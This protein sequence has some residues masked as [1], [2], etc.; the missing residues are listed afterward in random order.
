MTS[1]V[2]VSLSDMRSSFQ[3]THTNIINSCSFTQPNVGLGIICMST[4]SVN[5]IARG[6]ESVNPDE[7][8]DGDHCFHRLM[9]LHNCLYFC[10]PM[11]HTTNQCL[12]VSR[13]KVRDWNYTLAKREYIV[14]TRLYRKLTVEA[15]NRVIIISLRNIVHNFSEKYCDSETMLQNYLARRMKKNQEIECLW[16]CGINAPPII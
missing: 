8:C 5:F 13:K 15:L 11:D 9:L 7:R 2:T 12:S 16:K 4:S 10:F 1:I 14:E 6:Q 3:E